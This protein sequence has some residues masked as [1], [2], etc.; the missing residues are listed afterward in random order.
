MTVEALGHA[1]AIYRRTADS[2]AL[3]ALI[4]A[5]AIPLVG[6]LFLDWSLWTILVIYWLENGIVGFWNVPRMLLAGGQLVPEADLERAMATAEGP[7]RNDTPERRLAQA[8]LGALLRLGRNGLPGF[9]RLGLAGFFLVHYGIF[10]LVHGVFVFALPGF[11]G[12]LGGSSFT[13]GDGIP[14]SGPPFTAGGGNAFG[15]ILWGSVLLAVVALFISHGV[16]FLFNYVGRG[17][18]RRTSPAAQMAAPYTRVVALHLAIL[19]GAFAIAFVGAPVAALVILV[20][21]KTFFDLSLHLR[22]HHVRAAPA[23]VAAPG[24]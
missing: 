16:S 7:L 10:W 3:V 1:A 6:V 20:L 22:E 24:A 5:N 17:E 15:E 9:A 12:D 8:Q 18:Y 19:L 4:V 21:V 14:N 11:A 2:R 13:P 23:A